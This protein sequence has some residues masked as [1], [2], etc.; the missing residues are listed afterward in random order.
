MLSKSR[1]IALPE[2]LGTN[3]SARA[4]L[5]VYELRGGCFLERFRWKF[6]ER[7]K[8]SKIEGGSWIGFAAA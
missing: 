8:A 7:T 6:G 2:R 1:K 3:A 5:F 4:Y